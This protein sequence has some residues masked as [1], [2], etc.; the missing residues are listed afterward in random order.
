LGTDRDTIVDNCVEK[1]FKNYN[2]FFITDL[3]RILRFL[4]F[5]SHCYDELSGEEIKIE[6]QQWGVLLRTYK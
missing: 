1:N 2:G 6:S 5:L 3:K 4:P